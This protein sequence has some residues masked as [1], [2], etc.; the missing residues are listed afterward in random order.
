M[1]RIALALSLLTLAFAGG[2]SAAG[3]VAHAAG[4]CKLT[5]NQEFHSGA[6][7]LLKL[8]V[9]N[10]SCSTGLKVEKAFQ[11]CR[12][13]TAGHKTCKRRVLGYRCSQKVLDEI[14]SQ[15]D[16]KV[17]CKSGSREVDFTYTQNK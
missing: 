6:T 10:T 13:S 16:A 11:S 5:T 9:R 2:A 14:K 12:R 4:N 1:I 7:Y 15:Y 17:A 8:S 3:P